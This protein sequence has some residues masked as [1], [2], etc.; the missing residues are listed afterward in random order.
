MRGLVAIGALLGAALCVGL[1]AYF[2]LDGILRS[3]A[4]VGWGGFAL[5]CL[6]QL[7]LFP[8]L[9]SA[10]ATLS[11]ITPRP[12]RPFIIGRLMRDAATEILPLSPVGGF[13]I[14][15]R[16]AVLA[17]AHPALVYAT[18]IVDVAMELAAQVAFICIGLSVLAFRHPG[19][20]ERIGYAPLAA[21]LALGV[22]AAVGF[23]FAQ[24][25]A[26]RPLTEWARKFTGL[27][28]L[29][30]AEAGADIIAAIY[31]RP[32]R[33]A[34]AATLHLCGWLA[35]S[36]GAWLA[37]RLM[38]STIELPSVI[39]LECLLYAVR[40]VAFMA[41]AGLGVQEGAYAILGPLFGLPPETALTLSLLKRARDV[42]IYALA[43]AGWQLA[44]SRRAIA[45]R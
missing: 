27:A 4:A 41:P 28:F 20:T 23:I 14:G 40:S 45:A 42:A 38:G 22:A 29:A 21:G 3:F 6:A 8:L 2:G 16:A 17:G 11:P 37:L 26:L 24:R 19:A 9:G 35:A 32:A 39:A 13:V 10:W 34:L 44:E 12:W 15:G 1:V 5:V 30:T 36:A 18:T 7:A 31:A 25:F 43:L 33:L